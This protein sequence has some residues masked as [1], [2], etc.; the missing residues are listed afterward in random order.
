[1]GN[2][3]HLPGQKNRRP[4]QQAQHTCQEMVLHIEYSYIGVRFLFLFHQYLVLIFLYHSWICCITIVFWRFWWEERE[5]EFLRRANLI[6][7]TLKKR[8][9]SKH[10]KDRVFLY[11]RWFYES[12]IFINLQSTFLDFKF[13]IWYNL[14]NPLPVVNVLQGPD[15]AIPC[16][17]Y[18]Y[19]ASEISKWELSASFTSR[20]FG[21]LQL[22]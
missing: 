5:R 11:V 9:S 2:D 19:Q 7:F 6:W 15:Q 13:T 8:F 18:I 20:K 22:I 12:T 4:E 17:I 14:A 1:M 10:Y 3:D 21:V 16:N